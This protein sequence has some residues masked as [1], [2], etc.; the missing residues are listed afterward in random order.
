MMMN[1]IQQQDEKFG[2]IL[3]DPRNGAISSVG[4]V[5]QVYQRSLLDDGRQ[6]VM[7]Y[8][9]GRFK[10]LQILK[11]DPYMVALVDTEYSDDICTEEDAVNVEMDVWNC[12]KDVIRLTNKV[13]E[14][15]SV[16]LSEDVT[17]YAPHEDKTLDVSQD[18]IRRT[19]FS[20]ALA[21][22]LDIP[23]LQKQLMLQTVNTKERLSYQHTMLYETLKYL[24]AQS[25]LKDVFG[26]G[27]ETP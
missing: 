25:S 14:K 13:H 2:I 17:R 18:H 4:T 16:S 9:T 3:A 10:L 23:P 1:N 20:F 6:L 22:M 19:N 11:T 21:N 24:A 8:G 27:K 12:L 15:Q 7:N 26:G 5:V